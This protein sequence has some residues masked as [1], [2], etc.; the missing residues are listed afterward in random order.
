M[1]EHCSPL[2]AHLRSGRHGALSTEPV[3]LDEIP[4]RGALQIAG[5]DRFEEAALPVVQDLGFADLGDYATS[6]EAGAR[7]L[8]RTAPDRVLILSPA[9]LPP[10]PDI[11][12]NLALL[13]LSHAWTAIAV[14][15][16]SSEAVLSRLAGI[17]FRDT[18]FPVGRFTQTGIHRV[19]TL[20]LRVEPW[21]FHVVTPV[22]WAESLWEL[23]CQT[24]TPFGYETARQQPPD[25]T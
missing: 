12:P 1:L 8:F 18:A 17:D 5:W 13:D 6:R 23:I 20:I 21:A 15:G 10:V 25:V 14:F 22:T 3:G 24:A 11:G 16:R 7:R 4:V 19:R 9:A 2:A